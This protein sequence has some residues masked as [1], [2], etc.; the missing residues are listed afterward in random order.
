MMNN[1]DGIKNKK[2]R[3]NKIVKKKKE[4]VFQTF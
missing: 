3:I 1:E 4:K 2:I